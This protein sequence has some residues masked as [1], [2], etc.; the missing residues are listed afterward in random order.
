MPGFFMLHELK[1]HLYLEL[2]L[3]G[4]LFPRGPRHFHGPFK[5]VDL[6]GMIPV[7]CNISTTS[8]HHVYLSSI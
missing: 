8:R 4:Y 7:S 6:V 1:M 5:I 2:M 3:R